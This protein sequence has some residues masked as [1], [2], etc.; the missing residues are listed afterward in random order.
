LERAAGQVNQF[1]GHQGTAPVAHEDE[2]KQGADE[3]EPIAV[4]LLADL[5][6]GQ[7]TQIPPDE[8]QQVLHTPGVTLQVARAGH[9]EGQQRADDEPGAQEDLAMDLKTTDVPVEV[10]THLQFGERKRKRQRNH[11]GVQRCR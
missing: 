7:I 11:R 1:P 9:H 5:L 10:L 4:S 2:Q 6:T 3:G 8:L